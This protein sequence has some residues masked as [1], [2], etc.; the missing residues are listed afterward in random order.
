MVNYVCMLRMRYVAHAFMIYHV[1]ASSRQEP[2]LLPQAT[3]P[4]E[5]WNVISHRLL[6]N[7]MLQCLDAYHSHLAAVRLNLSVH[8]ALTDCDIRS[9]VSRGAVGYCEIHT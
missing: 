2:V 7:I 1:L 8:V 4:V 9:A 3:H 5:T 6:R